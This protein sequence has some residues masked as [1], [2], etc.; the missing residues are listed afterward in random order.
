MPFDPSDHFGIRKRIDDIT[1]KKTVCPSCGVDIAKEYG[2]LGY[3]RDINESGEY[4]IKRGKT[5]FIAE[6]VSN[7]G[8]AFFY[9][10]NCGKEL[11]DQ[12][13]RAKQYLGKS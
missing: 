7:Y 4:H 1:R 8:N 5:I 3:S 10:P 11:T 2:W 12:E 6:E 9:C 13:W